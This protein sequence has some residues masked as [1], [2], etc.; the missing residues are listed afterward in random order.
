[1]KARSDFAHEF[2]HLLTYGLNLEAQGGDCRDRRFTGAVDGKTSWLT[3]AS[4]T[5]AEWA[6][7]PGDNPEYRDGQVPRLPEALPDDRFAA[8]QPTRLGRQPG[9]PGVR[10][11][12]VPEPG[13][14]GRMPFEDFWKGASGPRT[15]EALD[16]LL[17]SRFPFDPHF[18]DFAREDVEQDPAGRSDR[19][20]AVGVRRPRCRRMFPPRDMPPTADL[21]A[22]V[23]D[24]DLP[25]HVSLAPLAAQIQRFTVRPRRAGWTST[26]RAPART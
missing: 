21:L 4:A 16:D 5:W 19:A 26:C 7:T 11:P 3:E 24:T 2:F 9:L 17:D 13:G 20:A 6:Y 22:G 8:R 14:G 10:L 18:R 23:S 12:A 1:M 15:R 25:F